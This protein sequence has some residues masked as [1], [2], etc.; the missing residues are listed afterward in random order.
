MSELEKRLRAEFLNDKEYAAAYMESHVDAYIATQIKVLRDR[1]EWNQERLATEAGMRQER[2]SV[3]EDVDY[4]SWTVN[5]LRKLARAFDLVL[6]VS[7]EEFGTE[8]K[9]IEGMDAASL[10]RTDRENDLSRVANPSMQIEDAGATPVGYV[11]VG[12]IMAGRRRTEETTIRK[13]NV[14]EQLVS[15]VRQG[16]AHAH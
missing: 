5:T 13:T 2:I 16:T 15:Q 7:F 12:T 11:E 14:T 4:S 3:L 10:L 6:R 1:N 8:L 9:K